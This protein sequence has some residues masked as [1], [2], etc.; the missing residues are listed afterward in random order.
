MGGDDAGDKIVQQ[1]SHGSR[2]SP[3]KLRSGIVDAERSHANAGA[4]HVGELGI[5]IGMFRQ[6]APPPF[7]DNDEAILPL[8]HNVRRLSPLAEQRK[9]LFGEEMA[10]AIDAA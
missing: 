3:E 10:L 9:K 6:D 5:H 1:D 2:V 8:L 4:I 7:P